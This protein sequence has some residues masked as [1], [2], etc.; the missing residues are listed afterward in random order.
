[1]KFTIMSHAC[2]LVESR[3]VS[4]MTDPWILG[5]CYWRS[6]W[7][8]PKPSPDALHLKKLD[9]IYLTHMHWDHFHGNSLR[10]LP[11][12]ATVLI[13]DAHFKRMKEDVEYIGFKNIIEIPH[14]DTIDLGN[15]VKVT[16]YQFGLC[17]DTALI[18]DDGT[19]VI[20]NLND[21]KI[22]GQ[23][24]RQILRRYPRVD[25]MFRSHSSAAPYPHCITAENPEELAYRTN[26]D[27]IEDFAKMA[28]LMNARFAIP[29]ASNHCFLHKE[30][31][32]FNST[33]ITP[34]QV[35]NYCERH[36][37][38][39]SECVVM[40]PGD[41]WSDDGG[42]QLQK[43]DFYDNR[44]AYIAAYAKEKAPVLEK[45]YA[46]QDAVELPFAMFEEYFRR[47]MQALPLA[48]RLV[49]KPIIVFNLV[50][51]PE[52]NWVVDFRT[53]RV[54]ETASLPEE[55]SFIMTMHP[56]I[57]RDCIEMRLFA[58]FTPS[59]R[60][61]VHL[62]KGKVKDLFFFWQLIDMYEYEYFPL[63]PNVLKPRFVRNWMR[64]WREVMMWSGMVFGAGRK[65]VG[66][67]DPLRAFVAKVR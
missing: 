55:Y 43:H 14:G 10:K 12:D 25:F 42:F 63:V 52:T 62:P 48:S 53:K 60:L 27:F 29:F 19:T 5:S 66:R 8:Y 11:Q 20:A 44:D 67:T 4:L 38:N 18:I 22:T 1:M 37:R 58:T 30:T 21:C 47:F 32:R 17:M 57:L 40:L 15:G 51:R 59:K 33:A 56:A 7:N 35:K 50:D 49:F 26:D 6:W 61:K 54:Y 13:P 28:E 39:D 9:Y 16:S 45:Y 2:M 36:L 3:G 23:P 65:V 24:L 34:A 64:R 31:I 46:E 41:S